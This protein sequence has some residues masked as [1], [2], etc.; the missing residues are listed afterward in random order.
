VTGPTLHEIA[1]SV[2]AVIEAAGRG[3]AH[4][5]G[6]AFGNRVARCV[7]ADRPDLVRSVTLLAAG[8]LIEPEREVWEA[9]ARCVGNPTVEDLALA[10]FAPGND[11]SGWLD[12]WS[13]DRARAQGAAVRATPVEDWW[14]AGAAPLLVVQGLADRVAVPENGRRLVAEAG[15]RARLVEIEGAGHALL[16]ERPDEV[17]AAV[18]DFLRS[19]E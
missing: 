19:Q 17:A 10:M 12:G 14:L 5:V 4:V 1:A 9:L 18:I 15:G 3:P 16:P 13:A 8:G 6:H 11:P 2:A 7:A